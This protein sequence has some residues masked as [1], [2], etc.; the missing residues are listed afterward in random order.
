MDPRRKERLREFDIECEN[1][2]RVREARRITALERE[3]NDLRERVEALETKVW[4]LPGGAG[5]MLAETGRCHSLEM[6]GDG[7]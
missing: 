3:N 2:V 4:Q 1:E 6:K 7:R 5:A